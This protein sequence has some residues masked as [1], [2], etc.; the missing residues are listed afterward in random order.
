MWWPWRQLQQVWVSENDV[1]II[2]GDVMCLGGHVTGSAWEPTQQDSS[3]GELDQKNLSNQSNQQHE[4]H[5][6]DENFVRCPCNVNEVC[7]SHT[8]L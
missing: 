7:V 3:K 2:C 4:M 8:A 1:H 5:T 6:S